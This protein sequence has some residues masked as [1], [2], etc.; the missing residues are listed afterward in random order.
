MTQDKKTGSDGA[1]SSTDLRAQASVR[2]RALLKLWGVTI[3][4]TEFLASI[5]S[6]VAD[7]A[8]TGSN[9]FPTLIF[10]CATSGLVSRWLVI[11]AGRAW[12]Y[13][14]EKGY[15]RRG[16]RAGQPT[17]EVKQDC[18][19]RWLVVMHAGLNP[20]LEIKG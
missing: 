9:Y 18:P 5:F 1:Q 17:I 14:C 8:N 12:T 16:D 4:T 13:A 6:Y 7:H 19:K 10:T 15:V 2:A 11:D 3:L 20:R